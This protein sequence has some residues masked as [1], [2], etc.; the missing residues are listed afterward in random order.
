[1][2]AQEEDKKRVIIKIPAKKHAELKVRLHYDDLTQT[3]FFRAITEAYVNQNELIVEFIEN[4]K[5]E[6]SLQSE[7][8]K[9]KIAK[10]INERSEVTK[11][12]ALGAS[13]IENIY[14][15]VEKEFPEL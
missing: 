14:D 15:L 1:M 11:K 9:K 7:H 8:K 4:H 5:Q 3:A 10:A 6:H 13:E 12:F 2:M